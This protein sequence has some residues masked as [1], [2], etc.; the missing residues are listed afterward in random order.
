MKGLPHANAVKVA[1]AL[2]S[3]RVKRGRKTDAD[4]VSSPSRT[5]FM[6]TIRCRFLRLA[7]RPTCA[8]SVFVARN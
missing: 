3:L 6:N 4:H 2:Q 5:L 1:T 7:V 8:P